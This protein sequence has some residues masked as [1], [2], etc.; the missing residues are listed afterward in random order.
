MKKKNAVTNTST[1]ITN[2]QSPSSNEESLSAKETLDLLILIGW[3]ADIIRKVRQ[4]EL[5]PFGVNRV[6]AGVLQ[7]IHNCGGKAKSNDIGRQIL[8]ERH[9]AHELL[10]RM[11]KI[12]L[13]KGMG[14][15][16]RKNGIT[17]ELTKKGYEAYRSI[18]KRHLEHK[19]FSSVSK[20]QREELMRSLRT[21]YNEASEI[22]GKRWPDANETS[23]DD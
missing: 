7:V 16:S 23:S 6:Q 21:L 15:P 11:E 22:L 12:G 4:K 2:K 19:I 17:F 13:I 14:D 3:T 1:K 5:V 20:I 8:R 18:T 10:R 9:S